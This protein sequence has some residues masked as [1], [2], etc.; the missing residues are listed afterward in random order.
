MQSAELRGLFEH[1]APWLRDGSLKLFTAPRPTLLA[2]RFQLR[3]MRGRSRIWVASDDDLPLFSGVLAGEMAELSVDEC[4]RTAEIEDWL[5]SWQPVEFQPLIAQP[6][7]RFRS[8]KSGEA[9]DLPYWFSPLA[10]GTIERLRVRDPYALNGERN[11]RTLVRFLAEF[12]RITGDW[13]PVIEV[14]FMD[15]EDLPHSDGLSVRQQDAALRR[16]LQAHEKPAG[17]DVRPCPI[18]RARQ[19][20]FHDR[21]VVVEVISENGTRYAHRYALS[22]GIDRFLDPRYECAVTHTIGSAETD[23]SR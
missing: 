22:G 7:V 14:L 18:R 4:S 12:A 3:A 15:P 8:Y 19:M 13:P 2:D 21:E 6:E 16:E 9:R 23:S 5:G 20:D 11:R 17:T 10:G 1:L